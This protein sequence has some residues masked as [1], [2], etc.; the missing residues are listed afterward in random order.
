MPHIGGWSLTTSRIIKRRA[1][2]RLLYT[3]MWYVSPDEI[4]KV[5]HRS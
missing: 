4:C 2:S 5:I 3:T 1:S